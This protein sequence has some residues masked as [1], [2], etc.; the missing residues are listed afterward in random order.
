M[1]KYKPKPGDACEYSFSKAK[2]DNKSKAIVRIEK[3]IDDRKGKVTA[4]VYEVIKDNTENGVLNYCH[5]TGRLML[6]DSVKYLR[7]LTEPELTNCETRVLANMMERVLKQNVNCMMD[8]EGTKIAL[9][10]LKKQIPTAVV[11][12]KGSLDSK[13]PNCGESVCFDAKYCCECGQAVAW[14]KSEIL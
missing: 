5:N 6:I 12:E 14:R 1:S 2:G 9:A 10:A 13:C 8:E 11:V 7:K 3:I 4:R